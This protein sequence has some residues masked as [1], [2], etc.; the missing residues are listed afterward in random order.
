[1]AD[2]RAR[3][4]NRHG[5]TR[6]RPG[7]RRTGAAMGVGLRVASTARMRN[8]AACPDRDREDARQGLA[9]ASH[10][11][12]AVKTNA[13]SAKAVQGRLRSACGGC[14]GC[15]QRA[16]RG[17]GRARAFVARRDRPRRSE[18]ARRPMRRG[19]SGGGAMI[20][21]MNPA[22]NGRINTELLPAWPASQLPPTI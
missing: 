1:M 13:S 18:A 9:K 19:S 21:S 6:S 22:V 14:H 12:V 10:D 16:R 3:L 8:G 7:I 15:Q 5:A 2:G 20:K 17:A 11:I 4:A